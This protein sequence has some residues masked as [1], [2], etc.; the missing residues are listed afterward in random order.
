MLGRQALCQDAGVISGEPHDPLGPALLDARSPS[1]AVRAAAGRRLA[2]AA[3]EPGV[4]PVL[5]RLL[6]DDQDTAVTQETAEALLER[7]D[8]HGL[9][10]VLAALAVAD[11]DT[12][13]HID[14]AL[15]NICHQ[16][17]EDEAR[18]RALASELV[19]DGDP[20]VSGMAR[21][22]LDG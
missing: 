6:L 15:H 7:W 10:L 9:R 3:R 14:S 20:G 5:H 12:G 21:E 8:V 16:S 1:W 19:R 18:L 4:A 17:R 2:V 13:D 22:I 11:D